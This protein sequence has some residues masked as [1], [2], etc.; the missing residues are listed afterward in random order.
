MTW[1]CV[2]QGCAAVKWWQHRLHGVRQAGGCWDE[3]RWLCSGKWTRCSASKVYE[4]PEGM[5][6]RRP[7]G[8]AVNASE[9][10]LFLFPN[11]ISEAEEQ[12]IV[13]QVDR[14][15]KRMRYAEAHF[16]RVSCQG[17][18]A[19]LCCCSDGMC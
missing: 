13:K 9:L 4:E 1:L 8:A 2:R 19:R 17:L 15:L 18:K 6:V 10:G 12:H 7:G 16:D 3:K 11:A 5:A 14:K